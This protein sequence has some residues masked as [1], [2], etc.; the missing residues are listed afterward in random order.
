MPQD[1]I[2]EEIKKELS[3]MKRA[4]HISDIVE[5]D[6]RRYNSFFDEEEQVRYS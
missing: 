2:L 6:Y 3:E 5:Q 4:E 1:N